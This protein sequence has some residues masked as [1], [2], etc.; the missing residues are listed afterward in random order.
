MGVRAMPRGFVV[1]VRSAGGYKGSTYVVAVA[2][3]EMALAM[4][5]RLYDPGA[6]LF[7]S[8]MSAHDIEQMGLSSGEVIEWH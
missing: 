7:A 5:K 6:E 2:E 8:P 1:L 4:V 3:R